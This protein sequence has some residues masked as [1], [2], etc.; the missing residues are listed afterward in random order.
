MSSCRLC[1]VLLLVL[2]RFG[3]GAQHSAPDGASVERC[4]GS[5]DFRV[6]PLIDGRSTPRHV[7]PWTVVSLLRG[8]DAP[9]LPL[10]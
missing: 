5:D 10:H 2:L 4:M 7:P 9:A 1:L 8:S 6:R 3:L